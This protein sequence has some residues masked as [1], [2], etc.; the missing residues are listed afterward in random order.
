MSETWIAV[1]K[2]TDR[3]IA[4]SGNLG[5]YIPLWDNP[6]SAH[7]WAQ[8]QSSRMG[9]SYYVKEVIISANAGVASKV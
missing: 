9:R 4:S 7:D 8:A 2:D 3:P 6:I 5:T 1:W